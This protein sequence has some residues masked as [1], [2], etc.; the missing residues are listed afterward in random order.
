M[1]NPPRPTEASPPGAKL[2]LFALGLAL[3]AVILTNVYIEMVRRSGSEDT[4]GVYL[5]TRSVRPGDVLKQQDVQLHRFP[6]AFRDSFQAMGAMD[7]PGLD[8][9]LTTREPTQRTAS[10]GDLLTFRLYDPPSS[11]ELDRN[12]KP[13][14]RQKSLQ[15]NSRTLPGALRE[16]MYVD[17]LAPFNLGGAVQVVPVIERVRVIALGS[18]T[19]Y[20][21]TDAGR[22]TRSFQTITIELESDQVLQLTALERLAAGDFELHL[23]NPADNSTP[24]IPDGGVNPRLLELIRK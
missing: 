16:G 21:D 3:L 22:S 11:S 10:Q 13:G 9:R 1:S 5:L 4:I 17:L 14:H 20:D 6:A 12:I 2:V 19:I 23:R 8:I 18:R 15:V 7:K 24:H